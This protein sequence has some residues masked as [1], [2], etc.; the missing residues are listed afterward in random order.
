[1]RDLFGVNKKV[2]FDWAYNGE[3][4]LWILPKSYPKNWEKNSPGQKSAF[5]FG[6]E[7]RGD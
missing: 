2:R 5:L 7:N 1:M 3:V 6:P 4:S